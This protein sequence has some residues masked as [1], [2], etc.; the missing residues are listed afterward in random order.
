MSYEVIVP[1]SVRKKIKRLGREAGLRVIQQINALEDNPHEG[2]K[3]VN[4]PLCSLRVGDY[5]VL[6]NIQEN[7]VILVDVS[8]RKKVYK[9]I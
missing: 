2:K 3:L 4:S 1:N 8:H 7:R 6:Y 5:R 9:R